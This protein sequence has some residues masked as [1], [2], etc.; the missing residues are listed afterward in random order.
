M[1]LCMVYTLIKLDTTEPR[2]RD[3]LTTRTPPL[4][5]PLMIT[6]VYESHP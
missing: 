3:L 6:T 1:H 2:A 4:D 5:P